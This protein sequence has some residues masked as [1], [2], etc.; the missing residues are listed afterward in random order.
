MVLMYLHG[1]RSTPMSKKGQI[2]REAFSKRLQYLAP[3]LNT[4]PAAVQTIITEAIKG[5]APEELCLVGSSLGGFYAT[6][7]ESKYSACRK[8]LLPGNTHEIDHFEQCLPE[9]ERFLAEMP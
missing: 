8:I 5:I 1:F 6:K 2:M 3:D 9:I 7:A 4:G